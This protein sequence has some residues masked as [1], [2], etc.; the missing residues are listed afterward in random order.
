MITGTVKAEINKYLGSSQNM[1]AKKFSVRAVLLAAGKG[2]RMKSDLPKVLHL[3]HG[4][5]MVL[6]GIWAAQTATG[7]KPVVIL[8]HAAGEVRRV[9]GERGHIVYQR[10]Q[11]GTGHAVQQAETYLKGKSD[12]VLVTSADMPLLTP[13]TL[14]KL[15]LA[16]KTHS[17]PMTI[18][19]VIADDPRGF[20]R[21]I[22]DRTGK[23]I[24]I[25]EEAVASPEEL[26][27]RELNAG[28]YCFSNAW[29]WKGLQQLEELPSG[30]Y[31]LTDLVGIAIKAG[32][33]VNAQIAV[34]PVETIG[35]NT[36]VHLQ[37]ASHAL[38]SGVNSGLRDL[39]QK[40]SDHNAW[41]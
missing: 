2:T 21:I 25:V 30:E 24:A 28:V 22:R 23:V 14:G 20:G 13:E 10:E 6:Y 33:D 18:L 36:P 37:E 8:G 17:G 40:D 4:N 7:A 15:I 1:T 35:I 38:E 16:Q 29:L 3:L 12:L 26:A 27:I 41:G 19:T 39:S 5:P 34:N 32:L 9:I 11:R 31:Y